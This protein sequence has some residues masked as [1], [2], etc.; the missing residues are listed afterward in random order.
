MHILNTQILFLDVP[1]SG[2]Y[3]LTYEA[4]KTYIADNGNYPV[5]LGTVLAGGSAGIANWLIGMPPDVLKSRL[6]TAPE[7]TY[8]KGIRDVFKHLIKS[9]GPLALYKGITPVLLRAFPANA[10]CFVGF[11]LCKQFLE[12]L[13]PKEKKIEESFS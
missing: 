4:I 7:G 5:I 6:Q 11:E 2:M 13:F 9:E 1:A 3:F 10:A 12:Y 8:P